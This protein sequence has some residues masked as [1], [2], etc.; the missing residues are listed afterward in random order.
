MVGIHIVFVVGFAHINGSHELAV[1]VVCHR[2]VVL[3]IHVDSA[4]TYQG[5]QGCIIDTALEVVAP[6]SE[7]QCLVPQVGFIREDGVIQGVLTVE[8][9]RGANLETHRCETFTVSSATA[10]PCFLVQ[11]ADIVLRDKLYVNR[12][13]PVHVPVTQLRSTFSGPTVCSLDKE[14]CLIVVKV[15][16]VGNDADNGHVYGLLFA[17]IRT[18]DNRTVQIPVLDKHE[19][20]DPA[21]SHSERPRFAGLSVG[22][23]RG[24]AVGGVT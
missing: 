11:T 13:V 19:P 2:L 6:V 24:R 23:R 14:P 4:G 7:L 22:A 16:R 9:L 10:H 17:D 18:G 21:R 5:L 15:C 3:Q 1:D 12:S 20:I 8:I